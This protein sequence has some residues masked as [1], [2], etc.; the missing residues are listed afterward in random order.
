MYFEKWEELRKT[1]SDD[2]LEDIATKMTPSKNLKGYGYN[3][4]S[5]EEKIGI[6]EITYVK[7]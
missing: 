2:P 4:Y 7:K 1:F 5:V 6:P 3:V